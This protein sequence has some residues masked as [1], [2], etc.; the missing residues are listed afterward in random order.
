VHKLVIQDLFERRTA[1]VRG[2]ARRVDRDREHACCFEPQR[3]ELLTVVFGIPQRE[4]HLPGK[5]GQLR[6]SDGG[7]PKE[8]GVEGREI[9]RGGHVMVLEYAHAAERRERRRHWRGKGEVEDRHVAILRCR[10]RK[11]KDLL[12]D[13]VVKEEI[14][15]FA[16]PASKNGDVTIFHFALPSPM[17][18]AFAS[19]GSVR[20][21]QYHNVTPAHYFAPFDASL[22]RLASVGRAELATLAGQVDLALG[23]SEY[24]RQELESLGFEATGVFPIAVDTS[25]VTANVRRPALEKILDDELV[26]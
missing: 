4:V 26:N 12:F 18:A 24:N 25:R 17:T 15:P 20:V 19:L 11:R 22:F 14:L 2:H 3:F 23:D 1:H 13:V 6:T 10:V 5:R 9:V 16:D 7:E 21:L 8:R